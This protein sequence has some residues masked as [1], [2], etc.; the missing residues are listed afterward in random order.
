VNFHHIG[1]L[2]S[3]QAER[4]LCEMKELDVIGEL[5]SNSTVGVIDSEKSTDKN[6]NT[7]MK[8]VLG[9]DK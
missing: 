6:L 7:F 9:I 2:G 1:V 5:F 8:R 4:G 3:R